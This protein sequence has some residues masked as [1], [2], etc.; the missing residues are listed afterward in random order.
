MTPPETPTGSTADLALVAK[1]FAAQL[2]DKNPLP[3]AELVKVRDLSEDIM[4]YDTWAAAKQLGAPTRLGRCFARFER[5]VGAPL[6]FLVQQGWQWLKRR[7]RP[8][9]AAEPSPVQ[10][11]LVPP[12]GS[13]APLAFATEFHLFDQLSLIH[14]REFRGSVVANYLLAV[15]ASGALLFQL[16][17][18]FGLQAA[19]DL[20]DRIP[21]IGKL[22]LATIVE[23]TC[24]VWIGLIYMRG[25]TPDRDG[26]TTAS[27]VP[28]RGGQRWHERWLEYRVLA[29]RFRCVD[30]VLPLVADV[31]PQ[32]SI[33]AERNA[34]RTWHH[35]FFLWRVAGAQPSRQTVAEYHLHALAVMAAQEQYHAQIRDRG[36]TIAERLHNAGY[37]FFLAALGICIWE[38]LISFACALSLATSA[39]LCGAPGKSGGTLLFFA[40]LLP[41]LSAAAYGILTHAE[42]TK[43][44]DASREAAARIH[45]LYADIVDKPASD[46]PANPDTL[47]AMRSIVLE[48]AGI[49]ITE[50]TNWRAM[51]R[52]KNVPLG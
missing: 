35:R 12:G 47:R 27:M 43:V 51:L 7:L 21:I 24:L 31:A 1:F 40:G 13:D 46:T 44:A 17:P 39:W 22:P 6:P 28:H 9:M 19:I 3:D 50:A 4:R 15:V 36:G 16:S 30:L 48:F 14:G 37:C 29:E 38:I 32:V 23:L 52:D 42:Y 25:S 11:Q 49:V 5:F 18:P 10:P 34:E 45:R 33:A 41:V 2:D 26:A 8:D 20:V